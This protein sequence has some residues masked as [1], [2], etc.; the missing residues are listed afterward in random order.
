M[1]T[2]NIN[3]ASMVRRGFLLMIRISAPI[4]PHFALNGSR[5]KSKMLQGLW[6]I[7]SRNG[8]TAHLQFLI[9]EFFAD[10]LLKMLDENRKSDLVC[11]QGTDGN[12]T[13][14]WHRSWKEPLKLKLIG[15]D[16][17]ESKRVQKLKFIQI[18]IMTTCNFKNNSLFKR[19]SK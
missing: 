16:G 17:L 15:P 11:D 4:S 7:H 10:D 18:I 5:R 6:D 2:I 9:V 8:L 3:Y 19:N 1:V 14:T 13:G 12:R